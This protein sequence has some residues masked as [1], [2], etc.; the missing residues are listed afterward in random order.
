[1]MLADGVSEDDD[2]MN[3]G[4]ELAEKLGVRKAVAGVLVRK[5][6]SGMKNEK[7]KEELKE[8]CADFLNYAH[9]N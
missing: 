5:L 9:T 4:I 8:A 6:L 1:M 2:K 3:V 7:T